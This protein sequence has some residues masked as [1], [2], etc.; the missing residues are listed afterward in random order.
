MPVDIRK[1]LNLPNPDESI[2]LVAET[3]EKNYWTIQCKYLDEE[4]YRLT[5]NLINTFT[6]LSFTVYRNISFGLV[7]TTAD[8]YSHKLTMYGNRLVFCFGDTW[9]Q[10]DLD[11]T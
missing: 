10:L 11:F 4:N 7:C 5:R 8:R 1:Y 2:D 9:R 6:D 3:K